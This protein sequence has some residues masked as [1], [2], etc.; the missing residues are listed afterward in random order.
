MA[1]KQPPG[2][3]ILPTR[4]QEEP[5]E[6]HDRRG[7]LKAGHRGVPR[8]LV[9][10][11][12]RQVDEQIWEAESDHIPAVM[13]ALREKALEGDERAA[14]CWLER[15][16]GKVREQPAREH[17]GPSPEDI[18]GIRSTVLAAVGADAS[19]LAATAK[20]RALTPCEA[21]QAVSYLRALLPQAAVEDSAVASMTDDMLIEAVKRELSNREDKG[22]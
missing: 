1:T 4:W 19:S 14:R 10:L 7:R 21:T 12:W 15:V 22:R 6:T 17:G 5:S 11:R 2:G 3:K 16:A 13:E 18:D 9:A 20:I 8:T